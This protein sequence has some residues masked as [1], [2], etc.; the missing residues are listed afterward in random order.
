MEEGVI[1]NRYL[2]KEIVDPQ[3]FSGIHITI[4][5][6]LQETKA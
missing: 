3:I 1:D 4:P 5:S 6:V 2:F